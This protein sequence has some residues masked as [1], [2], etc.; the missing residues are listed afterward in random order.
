MYQFTDLMQKV[1][2]A[3][4]DAGV[5]ALQV[6]GSVYQKTGA[7]DQFQ[8]SVVV[9]EFSSFALHSEKRNAAC[10]LNIVCHWITLL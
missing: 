5:K 1:A 2:D 3:L 10:M 9:E 6:K 8:V 4:A 7:L